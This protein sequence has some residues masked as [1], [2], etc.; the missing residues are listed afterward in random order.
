MRF[1]RTKINGF[2]RLVGGCN[3]VEGQMKSVSPD[4]SI[5]NTLWPHKVSAPVFQ[6]SGIAEIS[7]FAPISTPPVPPFGHARPRPAASLY[8]GATISTADVKMLALNC[9]LPQMPR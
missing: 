2:N 9:D 7:V 3:A 6:P 4:T 8:R 1:D 5:R